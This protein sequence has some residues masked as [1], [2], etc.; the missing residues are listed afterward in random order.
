MGRAP[1]SLIAISGLLGGAGVTLAALGA[2]AGGADALRAA[3]ELAMVHAAAVI[4]LV[5]V[6]GQ[7]TRPW[8]WQTI[9]AVMLLGAVLFVGTVSLGVLADLRPLPK[10]APTG[11]SLMIA[12]WVAVAVAGLLEWTTSSGARADEDRTV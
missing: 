11:G 10:L 12:T 6:S 1:A 4:G 5:A 7:A 8:L 3:A 9:A 2:H